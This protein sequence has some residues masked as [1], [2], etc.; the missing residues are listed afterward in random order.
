MKDLID[1]LEEAKTAIN[2][3]QNELLKFKPVPK[4]EPTVNSQVVTETPNP[5]L[6]TDTEKVMTETPQ[7]E[8]KGK[9]VR[10]KGQNEVYFIKDNTSAWVQNPETLKKLGFGFGDVKDITPEEFATY[11]RVS[12]INLHEAVPTPEVRQEQ[13]QPKVNSVLGYRENA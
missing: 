1:R 6:T 7:T 12:A 3:V 9:V 11:K 10:L 4:D 8:D 13:E 2:D 5:I